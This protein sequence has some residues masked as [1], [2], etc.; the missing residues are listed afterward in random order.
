MSGLILTPDACTW[1]SD[2]RMTEPIFSGASKVDGENFM[3]ETLEFGSTFFH[4]TDCQGRYGSEIG[5]DDSLVG[6]FFSETLRGL[7]E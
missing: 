6:T 2:Q 5:K 4:K 3:E 7:E 1:V